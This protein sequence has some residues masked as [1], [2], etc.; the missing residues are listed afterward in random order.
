M[1]KVQKTEEQW[2]TELEPEQDRILR[3]KGTE[4]PFAGEDDHTFEPGTYR[5]AGCGAELFRSRRST[6]RL[7]VAGVHA[8]AGD[9][10]VDEE[11][12]TTHGGSH[13]GM[14]NCGGILARLPGWTGTDGTRYCIN[15][16]V[17]IWRG[18]VEKK[19][20]RRLL[21]RRCISA[22]RR[23]DRTRAA[24]R[25]DGESSTRTSARTRRTRR[26]RRGH[27]RPE[28]ISYEKARRLGRSTTRPS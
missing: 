23:R 15:S 27:V 12:D 4:A 11:T 22:A 18:I 16:A 14:S 7:W 21:Q 28:R 2:R 13:R 3:G 17:P 19:A 6:T 1:T 25:R 26:G 9:D 10:A 24:G 20:R 8:L 5:C